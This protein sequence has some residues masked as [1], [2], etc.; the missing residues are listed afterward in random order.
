MYGQE[1][2]ELGNKLGL[3][4]VHLV[5][6]EG[7]FIEGT[8]FLEGKSVV[9]EETS[10]E[11]LKDLSGRGLLFKKETC[12]HAYPFCW[13]CKTRLIYYA[14]DSWYIRMSDLREKMVAENKK[15]HWE[16]EYIRDGRMGEWLANA[17]EWAI[18]R[19][20]YWGT[21][22]PV[23]QN[24]D[25]TERLVIGSI[26]ELKRFT[27]KSGNKYF[28]MRHGEAENNVKNIVSSDVY[29]GFSLTNN[30]RKQIDAHI[31][32]LKKQKIT[33]II[34]SPFKRTKE[35]AE[36]IASALDL[37]IEENSK[38]GELNFGAFNGRSFDEYLAFENDNMHMYSD[39]IQGGE[40]YQDAKNRFGS[41][42]Y[43]LEQKYADE[44]ILIVSHGI[45]SEVLESV[46]RGANAEESKLII[47]TID[48]KVAD[49]RKLDFVALPHNDDYEL[50]LHRPY[51]DNV[52]LVS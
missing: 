46:V 43:E 27:K 34:T 1:D 49:L 52:V 30:G 17:K 13:R 29:D 3:P 12:T 44:K 48:V 39:P 11:I 19:E 4:K 38:L 8:G 7:K 51:I 45:A 6:P 25:G 40:S 41:V 18:S 26:D 35:S 2:F 23:W 24:K 15:I 9:D 5:S 10:V 28:V 16:P 33:R 42:L 47:D 36:I 21:P 14:R 22:L 32:E 37:S 50:D 20:R 31:Q